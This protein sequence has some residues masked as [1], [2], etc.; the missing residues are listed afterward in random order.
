MSTIGKSKETE[1]GFSGCPE[2]GE[3]GSWGVIAE[4]SRAGFFGGSK[5]NF[6]NGLC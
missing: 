5:E 3:R 1:S 2:L 4:Q 6:L